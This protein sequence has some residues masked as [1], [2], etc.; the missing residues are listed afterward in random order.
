MNMY[1]YIHKGK[2]W[3]GD[4]YFHVEIAGKFQKKKW[5]YI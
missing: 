1:V 4:N 3:G 5:Q 2:H